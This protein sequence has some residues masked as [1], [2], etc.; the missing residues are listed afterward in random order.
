MYIKKK[1]F[2]LFLFFSITL[3]SSDLENLLDDLNNY[4]DKNHLN[5]D[6]KASAMTVLYAEDLEILGITT[7]SEALDFVPGIQ[8]FQTTYFSNIISS[9]GYSQPFNSFQDKIRFEIDG[10]SVSSNYFENFPMSLVERI[11]IS[12]GSASTIYEQSGYMAVV[13]IITKNKNNITLGTGSFDRRNGSFIINEK[14]DDSWNIKLD[15]YYLKHNKTVDAPNG[16]TTNSV[17]F[18]TTF[19]RKKESLE[20]KEDKG[21]GVLLQNG[22]FKVS[23]RYIE[24]FKQNNYGFAGYLDFNDD[25]YSEYKTFANQ[26]SYDTFITQNNSLETKLSFL[27]NNYQLNTFLYDFEPNNLGIYNPHYKIDY[28]QQ[29]SSLSFL[30][31]NRT[32]SKHNIEYGTQ[33]SILSVPKNN[34]YANVDNLYKLGFYIPSYNAYFPT[35]RELI[36]FSGNDGFLGDTNSR[37]NLSYFFNDKYNFDENLSFLFNLSLDDY[38]LN[39]KQMNYKLGTVYSNDDVN[40]YKFILSQTNRTPS[41]I[42]DSIVGHLIISGNNNL[43]AEKMQNAEI[44]YIYQQNTQKLKLNFFYSIYK[45]SIDLRQSDNNTLEYFNKSEDD[46]SY[47]VEAEYTKNFENRSKLLLGASYNIFK[48]KNEYTNLDINTP[49]VSKDT[50][51]LGYIYPLNS[52]I[53]LS[54]LARYYGAKEVLENNDSIPSVVLFDLGTQYNFSKNSKISFNVKNILDKDYFYWGNNIADERML[55]EGR[56]FYTSLSYDF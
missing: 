29:E 49:L 47:G 41:M 23:S 16:E 32:F 38:D 25:S 4:S 34:Y 22:N 37:T 42:E 6:Y 30:I 11:E 14:F 2:V 9:R 19:N 35:Q 1:Y 36:K 48:Y 44:M 26:I 5:I 51:N 20:G 40:I 39:D 12:K 17:Y 54:S 27:Q 24:N 52:K 46:T 28:T 45:N 8:T 53:V 43:E 7:L 15:T 33:V 56:I 50:I 55:R 18:G 3:Y 31:K 21:I 10:I 13:N